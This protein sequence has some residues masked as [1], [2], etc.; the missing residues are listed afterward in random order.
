LLALFDK[1]RRTGRE[2]VR[3]EYPLGQRMYCIGDIH[4]RADLLAELHDRIQRDAEA[5][6]GTR[7]VLYL[8]DYIDRG[9]QSR[10][11]LD[12]L[13]KPAME[14]F[15]R[16]CL[17][18]NHEQALLDFLVD[19]VTMAGWLTWGGMATLR[20]YGVHAGPLRSREELLMLR[21]RLDAEL[22]QAHR[23]FLASCPPAWSAG[24]YFFVHAGIRPGV[25][26]EKQSVEDQLWIGE[27]F[28]SSRANHGAIVVHGHSISEQP[29]FL[30]NRIGIDTGAFQSGVLT[31]LVL[32]S[33]EQRLLQTGGPA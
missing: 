19:P 6:D 23:E 27:E 21:D 25:A 8:G 10:E 26:L 3:P 1:F 12:L 5:F 20:S 28:T 13:I 9:E 18:G 15:E 22:P 16:I 30:P 7:Q 31:A 29:E 17:L 32:E 33:H 4:G 14:N 2:P 24:G 11:V